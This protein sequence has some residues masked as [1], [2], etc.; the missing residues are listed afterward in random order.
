MIDENTNRILYVADNL[1]VM[2]GIESKSIDLIATDPPFNSETE[3]QRS[4]RV[5]GGKT[6][7]RRPLALGRSN[8]RMARCHRRRP[9][10]HQGTHRG[11]GRYR[12]RH[13]IHWQSHH[14][15]GGTVSPHSSRGWHHEWS[16]CTV[17]SNPRAAIYMHCDDAAS[18][19]LRLLLDAVF[20]RNRFR[21]EIVWQRTEGKGLNPTKYVRN[22]DRILYYAKGAK[23]TWNQQYNPFDHSYG[24]NWRKD[25]RG[26]WEAENLTGGKAGSAEAYKPFRGVKPAAGRAWAPPPRN[27][28]PTDSGLPDNYEQ[29]DALSKCEALDAVGLIYWPEKEN[30]VPRYKK[31]LS[32]LKGIYASDL[33][34]DIPPVSSHSDERTGWAT[35]KPLALYRRMIEASSNEGDLVLDPFCGCA[36][37]CVA[38]EQLQ[39]RW[40]GIDIDPEAE[41]VTNDRLRSQTGIMQSI[42]GNPVTV[43]KNPSQR[44]DIP[45]VSEAKLR[46]ILWNN[47]GRRCANPYC[48]SSNLRAEDLDLDHRIPKSRGGADDQSNRIGLCGNCNRRKGAKAWGTF[49]DE[50]RERIPHPKVGADG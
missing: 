7:I 34:T 14:W 3:F 43:R 10:G 28:F 4:A 11:S 42:D 45:K 24:S 27:K 16:K 31:Y 23:P 19:Y 35:Q 40:I 38:A 49:L 21:N 26:P 29:L 20:G 13:H 36:T 32:T 33:I 17:F 39:R 37:T 8:R 22:C 44:T 46:V 1:R 9:S 47:Q 48:D 18:S 5:E 6:E 15:L 41:T 30:G 12:G 50:G 2:R 25:K